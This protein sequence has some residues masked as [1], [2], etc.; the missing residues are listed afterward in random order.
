MIKGSR[1]PSELDLSPSVEP[2]SLMFEPFPVSG[3]AEGVAGGA[4]AGINSGAGI[5]TRVVETTAVGIAVTGTPNRAEAID[6]ELSCDVIE[7]TKSLASPPLSAT[8]RA[9]TMTE[10]SVK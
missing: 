9:V 2:D 3:E 10:P 4:G 8:M 6:V 7:V 1:L 5:T